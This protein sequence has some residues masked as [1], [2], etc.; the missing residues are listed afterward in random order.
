MSW[1][2]LILAGIIE[3]GWPLGLKL[4]QE[5]SQRV[6]GISISLICMVTSGVLFFLAQQKISIST[7][8]AVWT[9]MG[10]AGT[11]FVGIC[12]FGDASSSLKFF[13][14]IFIVIGI[15]SLKIA[16]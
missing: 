10:A 14:I 2:Y 7:S 3:V 6:L 9:G 4:A 1:F 8:Y 15:I 13:G 12:Y 5:S 11:F 16:N